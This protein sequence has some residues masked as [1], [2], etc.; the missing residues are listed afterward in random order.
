[1]NVCVITAIHV[2][3]IDIVRAG[4]YPLSVAADVEVPFAV[5]ADDLVKLK[6][7]I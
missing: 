5:R 3:G 1:M 4:K 6:T 2:F 7:Y